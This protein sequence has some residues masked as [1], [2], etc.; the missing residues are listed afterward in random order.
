[1]T[2]ARRRPTQARSRARFDGILDAAAAL[3]GERGLDPVTMTDVA[4]RAG[5]SVTALYR[6]FP[7]KASVVRELALRTFA[8][9]TETLLGGEVPEGL[10]AEEVIA[11]G[12]A[13]FWRRHVEEPFRLQLRAAVHADAELS[14]LDLA[15]SRRNAATIAAVLAPLVG[16]T[17]LAALEREAL[18][19]VEAVDSV[20][21][22]ADRL[23]ETEAAAVVADFTAMVTRTLTGR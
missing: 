2:A 15:E 1:M 6:Y 3:I 8:H 19:V 11:A 18:L 16:R 12:V 10:G 22:L 20:M 4:D 17:D 14:A 21:R 5:M 9:D 7:N 13:E 23:D